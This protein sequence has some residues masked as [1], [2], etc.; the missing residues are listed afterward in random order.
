MK[1]LV[2]V[3]DEAEARE[4]ELHKFRTEF[5]LDFEDEDVEIYPFM[6]LDIDL[7]IIKCVY[8]GNYICCTD[9]NWNGS[10]EAMFG[11]KIRICK[12]TY[13]GMAYPNRFCILGHNS[14]IIYTCNNI[15]LQI[16][17]SFHE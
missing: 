1:T 7:T 13:W 16:P 14:R 6:A 2:T 3:M 9:G 10:M 8:L 4:L 15:F 5:G 11:L 12:K 17:N